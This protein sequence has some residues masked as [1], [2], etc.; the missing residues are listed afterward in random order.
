[1]LLLS[2]FFIYHTLK[3]NEFTFTLGC[4]EGF[5]GTFLTVSHFVLGEKDWKESVIER[6]EGNV[7]EGYEMQGWQENFRR[8][9]TKSMPLFD[10]ICV[11]V[12]INIYVYLRVDFWFTF[13]RVNLSFSCR[14]FACSVPSRV[15]C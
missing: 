12:G 14:C 6:K 15:C 4:T 1:M 5:H 13:I 3:N 10:V 7:K 9:S 8:F 11:C 2:D